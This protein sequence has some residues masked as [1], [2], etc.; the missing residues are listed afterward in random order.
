[1]VGKT[2][3]G[4]YRLLRSIG[5][6]SNAEVFL[7]EP[8]RAPEYRVV[9]KRRQN[10][11]ASRRQHAKGWCGPERSLRGRSYPARKF[12]LGGNDR[13]LGLQNAIIEIADRRPS[14]ERIHC[15]T[16]ATAQRAKR[17]GGLQIDIG[18]EFL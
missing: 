5:S 3:L 2:A 17:A 8:L 10:F 4:K 11:F 1:M 15:R 6:G 7:A 12:G 13:P 18:F 16:A 9:V 14:A